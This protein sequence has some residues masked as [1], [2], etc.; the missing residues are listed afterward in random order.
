MLQSFTGLNY[1]FFTTLQSTQ[2]VR[3]S[4]IMKDLS[5]GQ[6][7]SLLDHLRAISNPQDSEDAVHQILKNKLEYFWLFRIERARELSGVA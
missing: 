2:R 5:S 7:F 3:L 1:V 4:Q 6:V